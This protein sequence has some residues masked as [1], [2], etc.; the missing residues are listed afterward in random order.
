ML[1]TSSEPLNENF[2]KNFPFSE[3]CIVVLVHSSI[4]NFN[5]YFIFVLKG[6]IILVLVFSEL[7]KNYLSCFCFSDS[8]SPTHIVTHIVT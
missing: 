4:H 1:S 2:G 3:I 8:N 7:L 5:S 6:V